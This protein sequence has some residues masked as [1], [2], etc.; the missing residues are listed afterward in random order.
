MTRIGLLMLVCLMAGLPSALAATY[1]VSGKWA[2]DRGGSPDEACRN[3]PTM[4]FKG[5]RRFDTGGSVP[6]YRNQSI[7]S[8]G[9]SRYRVVD[10]FFN[11]QARGKVAYTL[12]IVDGDRLELNLAP[13][14]TLVRLR[15]CP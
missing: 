1:P 2:Y 15:R 14:G 6:D 13:R 3:G 4:E 9:K 12:Q 10:Q 7:S 8:A 5:D 11:G